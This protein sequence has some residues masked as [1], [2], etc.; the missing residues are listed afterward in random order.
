MKE[1]ATLGLAKLGLPLLGMIPMHTELYKP[2]V[3]QACLRLKGEFI[4]GSQHKRR[5][6]ARI[7]VGAMSSR[8]AERLLQ[9]GTLVITPGDREDLIMMILNEGSTPRGHLAG[10]V[11][12]DGILPPESVMQLIRERSIPF[13][14]TTADISS[15]AT[16]IS[17]MT[18][19]TEVGDRDKIGVIQN[20]IQEHVQV[21]RIIDLVQRQDS[22]SNRQL[23]L[24]V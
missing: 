9:P 1:Y 15:A 20:L 24:G 22:D 3:N 12:T 6:V 5:R 7:G 19:K 17:H 16:T 23:N 10:V 2:T 4:A 8:N 13:I 21:D 11:L 14:S 18:V